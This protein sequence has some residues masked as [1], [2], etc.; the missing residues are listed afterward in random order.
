LRLCLCLPCVFFG[1]CVY[2]SV[3][4]C[5]S[6]QKSCFLCLFVFMTFVSVAQPISLSLPGSV[7]A[8]HSQPRL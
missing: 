2:L 5:L 7:Y 6:V 8:S 4:A 3:Y 1:V